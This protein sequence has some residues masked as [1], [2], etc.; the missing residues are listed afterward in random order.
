VE[1]F[2]GYHSEWN[3]GSPGGWDYQCTTQIIGKEVWLK[4]NEIRSIGI[5]LDM[6]HPLFF[7]LNGFT[8]MLIQAHKA[9]AGNNP[10]LI[11]VVA[12]EE[13][14]ESVT[15]NRN[16]AE[17]L[18]SIEGITGALISP[19]EIELKGSK[20]SWRGQPISV[21][22]VDF[23]TDV[24]LALHRK[25]NLTP[26]LQAVKENR[27]INPRG[28]EP[29]N[30]K[31]MFEVISGHK[32]DRFHPEIVQR[33]PW[34]RQFFPRKTYGPEGE[35]IDDLIEW[36][37]T[38][39]LNL[40]LKPERGYSGKGVLV[41]ESFKNADEAVNLA[42]NHGDYIVQEK[43]PLHLWTENIPTLNPEKKEI[44]LKSYQTDFRSLFGPKGLFGFLCRFGGIPT[45]VGSGG[46]VQPLAVLRS[47]M[48]I[49]EAIDRIN[50]A[51]LNLGY[52]NLFQV[53]EM[54]KKMSK[55]H[56]LTYL[57]G[58]IKV[59]VRPRLLTSRQ[60]AALERYC[61][62]VWA[63]C[64]TLEKIW[65]TGELDRMIHISEDEL[66]IAHMQPWRGGPAIF[67]SD[68]LFNFDI[69]KDIS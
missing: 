32:S 52:D 63:D 39:W 56:E 7:P 17:K 31:S 26:L 34:T 49:K 2:F 55:D 45:N 47:D 65:F 3:L 69:I 19:Q 1:D 18:S 46:G 13:T 54:Q 30:I 21:L 44:T 6:D 59:A 10:G 62:R 33:T 36:T 53:I 51:I 14:L 28:T 29:I 35:E 16:L 20:V 38:H 9:R 68:G 60:L 41:G 23:N 37:R 22:F 57:L 12:E 42:L 25:H 8:E 43:I 40:V 50:D 66:E 24:L 11:A 4:L 61:A 64:L 67:A 27:V 48:S 5:D 58:P 15:E